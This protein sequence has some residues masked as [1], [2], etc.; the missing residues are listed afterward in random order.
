MGDRH[1]GKC[2]EGWG[3]ESGDELSMLR[4]LTLSSL[5]PDAARP[6]FG[7]FVEKQTLALA[8]HPDVD[9]RVVAPIGVPPALLRR[10]SALHRALGGQPRR[11]VWKGLEVYRPLFAT[12]PFVDGR[13]S[14][15][16]MWWAL[17][18]LLDEIRRDFPF[19][20]IDT[21]FFFPD[22]PAAMRLA[23]RYDVPLSIK[24]RGADISFW[25][26]K[27]ACRRQ[28][29]SAGRAADGML[30]V[31]GALREEMIAIGMPADRIT[32]HH[33]GVDQGA[34]RPMDRAA[35]KAALGLSG[36]IILTVG[37]LIP[38]KGQALVIDAMSSLS[39]ATLLIVGEGPARGSLERQIVARGLKD[40][41]RMLGPKPHAELPALFAAADVMAL[42]SASEGLA[43]VWIESLACGTPI[44]ITD[45]GGAREVVDRPAA[46]R[47]VD[48]NAAAIAAG[49]GAVLAD[50]VPRD[51]TAETAKRFTWK[52]N[53]ETL[54]KHLKDLVERA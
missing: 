24:A 14:A 12:V 30:A 13:W 39:A 1:L 44:V 51:E 53:T 31:S 41:V 43:N 48:R 32:V 9:L 50:P 40:R 8:A 2:M 15:L 10:F 35:A 20:I 29:V 26:S 47:I 4:V 42:P 6:T 16:S 45:I 3:R 54:Y 21:E 17:L 49:I 46:G 25:S 36:P 37:H 18:P 7:I 5:F 22:G 27:A 23:R 19:D 38:R 34:F 52:R 33:T 11:E 28:I